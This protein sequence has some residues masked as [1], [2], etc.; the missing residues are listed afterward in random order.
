MITHPTMPPLSASVPPTVTTLITHW[1]DE[2]LFA[3]DASAK[4]ESARRAR[5]S[6]ASSPPG[7]AARASTS[8]IRPTA[9]AAT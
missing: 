2:E 3:P 9:V 5:A 8:T 7:A 1:K 6:T 4:A